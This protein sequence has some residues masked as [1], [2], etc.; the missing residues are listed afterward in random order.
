MHYIGIEKLSFPE[1][2]SRV[3]LF[4]VSLDRSGNTVGVFGHSEVDLQLYFDEQGILCIL[5]V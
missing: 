4:T 1:L 3:C 5:Y 2:N